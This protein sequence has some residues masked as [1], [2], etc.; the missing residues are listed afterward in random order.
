MWTDDAGDSSYYCGLT[1]QQKRCDR[2]E[3]GRDGEGDERHGRL[4]AV[5]QVLPVPFFFYFSFHHFQNV[6][7]LLYLP[8][9]F[10]VS[11]KASIVAPLMGLKEKTRYRRAITNMLQ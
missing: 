7:P 5:E 11:R 2:R 8:F 1:I 6:A 10:G 4:S 3:R 9:S